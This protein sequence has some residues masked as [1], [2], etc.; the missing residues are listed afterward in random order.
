MSYLIS[1]KTIYNH[2]K[3]GTSFATPSNLDTS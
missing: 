3:N 1:F 2:L